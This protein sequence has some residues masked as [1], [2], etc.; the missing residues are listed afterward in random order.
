LEETIH[1][2]QGHPADHDLDGGSGLYVFVGGG[3]RSVCS[4]PVQNGSPTSD[5][6]TLF[7]FTG[8]SIHDTILAHTTRC[9]SLGVTTGIDGEG[10][11]RSLGDTHDTTGTAINDSIGRG[12]PTPIPT[13]A[14]ITTTDIATLHVSAACS[15]ATLPAIY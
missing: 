2:T 5:E 6:G 8:C 10:R 7:F 12:R 13:T 9:V 11:R 4:Q 15:L 14:T 3:V 1:T